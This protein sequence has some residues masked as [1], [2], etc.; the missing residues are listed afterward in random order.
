MCGRVAGGALRSWALGGLALAVALTTGCCDLQSINAAKKPPVGTACQIATTWDSC[1]ATTNDT[2][3]GG[4]PLRGL[5]GRLYLFDNKVKTP[6]TSEGNVIVDLFD[7]RPLA[8]GGQPIRLERWQFPNDVVQ[9]LLK[10]D[11]FGWGYALFLP[12]QTSYRPDITAVHLQVCF[13]SP[14]GVPVY[15]QTQSMNLNHGERPPIVTTTRQ[16][17]PGWTSQQQ[18]VAR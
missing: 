3:N 5:L 9:Q 8:F 12:W 16:E 13:L 15:T 14:N 10:E 11:I 6:I 17:I 4:A 1:L 2:V 18:V 7:D